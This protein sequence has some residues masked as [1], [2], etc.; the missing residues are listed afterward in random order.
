MNN[1]KLA[2]GIV[3]ATALPFFANQEQ[4][5]LPEGKD[6]ATL[7][8][9][10]TGCHELDVILASR[11]TAIGWRQNVDDMVSRGAEGSDAEMDGVVVYLTRYF[12]K[13]NVNTATQQQLQEILGFAEKEAQAIVTYREHHGTI[14]DFEQL[15]TVPGVSAVNLQQKRSLIAFTL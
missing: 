11:R 14:K 15:Q 9:I 2:V 3:F 12:G 1:W 7:Q 5:D 8:R 4:T 6:K 13:L 10:C